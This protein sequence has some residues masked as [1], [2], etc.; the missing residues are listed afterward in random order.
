MNN[1]WAVFMLGMVLLTGCAD[2]NWFYRGMFEGLKQRESIANPRR[3]TNP[4][5]PSVSYD[6]YEAERKKLNEDKGHE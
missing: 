1:L 6:K 2:G 5:E 3:E 4:A